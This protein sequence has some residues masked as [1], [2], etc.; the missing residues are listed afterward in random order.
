MEHIILVNPVAGRKKGEKYGI[1]IQILLKKN[2]IISSIHVSKGP[3][4]LIELA[5][6]FSSL[7]KCRF[8]SVGGD[9]TLN[10]IMQGIIGTDSEIV[11]TA[12]GTGNDFVKSISKYKSMRKII[13][14]SINAHSTDIDIM[15]LN[16]NN[17]CINILSAGFDAMVGKNVDKFRWLPAVSGTVKYNLSILYTL[18]ENK[19]F[20]F[21]VR[22]NDKV[23]KQNFT[24]VAISN[25][26]FY[27]G[28]ICPS[29]EAKINDGLLDICMI[30]STSIIT[31][32]VLLPKYKSSKHMNLKQVKMETT[33]KITIVSNKEF[34]V[35]VD[36][37]VF[38]T[39][40]LRCEI[41]PNCIKIVNT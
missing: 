32:L 10:E 19:N 8:Y 34:P 2:N 30:E 11:V 21:K 9:G 38:Y 23:I 17:Y 27:G 5:K 25:G 3:E 18:F 41:I 29:P 4:H 26:K 12:C 31:K 36:G 1:R 39:K 7:T 40:K 37:E 22:L 6:E 16:N 24:L 35:N 15:K 28:G 20:K 33:K 14:N 13:T